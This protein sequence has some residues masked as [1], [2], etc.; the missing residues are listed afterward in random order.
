MANPKAKVALITGAAHGIGRAIA[1]HLLDN[2]WRVGVVDLPGAGFKRAYADLAHLKGKDPKAAA[3]HTTP[4]TVAAENG[5]PG[6][7]LFVWLIGTALL[8]A[9]RKLGRNFDGDGGELTVLI[10]KQERTGHAV[11]ARAGKRVNLDVS[12]R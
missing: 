10:D 7:V 8:L 11:A 2:D 6:L 4:I 1:R 12:L 5:L 3:S 9:F